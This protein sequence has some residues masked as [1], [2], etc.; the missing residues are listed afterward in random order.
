[1]QK[2]STISIK[3]NPKRIPV[4]FHQLAWGKLPIFEAP[5][6]RKHPERRLV[7]K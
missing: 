5:E 6:L 3:D 7:S 1:M 4:G 2:H